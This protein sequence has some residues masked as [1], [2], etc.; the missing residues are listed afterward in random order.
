MNMLEHLAHQVRAGLGQLLIQEACGVDN[1]VQRSSLCSFFETVVRDH[2]KDHAVTAPT[3]SRSRSPRVVVHQPYGL[4][5]WPQLVSWPIG[6]LGRVHRRAALTASMYL[7]GFVSHA[8]YLWPNRL[9]PV[10]NARSCHE[11]L[12]S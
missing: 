5:C 11:M 9:T 10:L 2:S 12:C 8:L 3:S 6:C 7:G 1:G 4:N